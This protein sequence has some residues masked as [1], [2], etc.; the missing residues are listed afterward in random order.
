M[1]L[2]GSDPEDALAAALSTTWSGLQVEMGAC[3]PVPLLA[4]F[5]AADLGGVVVRTEALP[6][7]A[8]RL[9]AQLLAAQPG[10]PALLICGG[11]GLAGAEELLALRGARVLPEPWTPRALAALRTSLS[12]QPPAPPTPTAAADDG[13]LGRVERRLEELVRLEE[14][15]R[16]RS[17][18]LARLR[19]GEQQRRE[20]DA[21]DAVLLGVCT[22]RDRLAELAVAARGQE[23]AAAAAAA[24]RATDDLLAS[25]G[26]LRED[27]PAFDDAGL[28]RVVGGRPRR[29]G[30]PPGAALL[31]RSAFFRV[32][33]DRRKVLRPAEFELLTDEP[34]HGPEGRTHATDRARH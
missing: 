7:D 32:E 3:A 9:L 10:L 15:L 24:L 31:R 25:H 16:S 1:L 4:A 23:C 8:L 29:P 26:V 22:L 28:A 6:L 12:A 18:E 2:L 21:R 27:R 5:A 14:D 13:A 20:M 30:D 33:Q 11:R 17:L 34:V 19:S